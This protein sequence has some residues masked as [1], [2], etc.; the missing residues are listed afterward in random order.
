[1]L[2]ELTNQLIDKS[3]FIVEEFYDGVKHK[4]KYIEIYKNPSKSEIKK[5]LN[6]HYDL[7]KIVRGI[8]DPK[9]KVYVTT[10]E[11]FIHDNIMHLLDKHDIIQGYNHWYVEEES[12]K[13]FIAVENLYG[14]F[15]KLAESYSYDI[16]KEIFEKYS[17][18]FKKQTGQ[19]LN[20]SAT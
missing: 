2:N 7:D 17:K 3:L 13:Y 9:G 16:P 5:I 8:V 15:W 14:E 12:L 10:N 11:E 4:N 6:D 18:R 1:M 19:E 20:G